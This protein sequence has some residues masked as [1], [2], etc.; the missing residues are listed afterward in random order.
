MARRAYPYFYFLSDLFVSVFFLPSGCRTEGVLALEAICDRL[1]DAAALQDLFSVLS[2]SEESAISTFELLT[3]GALRRLREYLE[4][5]DLLSSENGAPEDSESRRW[6]LLERLGRFSEIALPLG[7]G[8]HP[9]MTVLVEKLQSALSAT[10]KFEVQVTDIASMPSAYSYF[11]GGYYGG[12]GGLS[13]SAGSG[14]SSLSAGL[15]ALANPFKIRLSRYTGETSLRDYST[16]VVLIEPLASM[17][18][19]EEFLWP[20]VHMSS[21]EIARQE[22]QRAQQAAA[23]TAGAGGA[24]PAA[25]TEAGGSGARARGSSRG[26][27]EREIRDLRERGRSAAALVVNAADLATRGAGGGGT[28]AS[29][30]R[31]EQPPAAAAAA[32]ATGSGPATRR[33]TQ[34]E[35]SRSRPIPQPAGGAGGGRLTRAQAR[36]AAEAEV[37]DQG[38]VAPL[39]GVNGVEAMAVDQLQGRSRSPGDRPGRLTRSPDD[40]GEDILFAAGGGDV[41]EA[42]GL[43]GLGIHPGEMLDSD[44]DYD[45]DEMEMDDGYVEGEEDYEDGK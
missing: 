22:Q 33:S 4:G 42:A 37:A 17:S 34:R 38:A 24:G 9:P 20:R 29:A 14:G 15:A 12:R 41:G 44:G 6:I 39:P 2:A 19:V 35:A 26:N 31:P 23:D 45:E 36:A 21:A 40:E 18:Q 13:R 5:K 32:G 27:R 8:G 11:P 16:N 10:D 7:S 25:D 3:S 43:A 1:P 30:L 28:S